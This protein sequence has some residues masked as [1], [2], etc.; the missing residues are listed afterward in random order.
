MAADYLNFS[1]PR[2]LVSLLIASEASTPDAAGGR[3]MP[4]SIC[5]YYH[6][7]AYTT[8]YTFT[9][10]FNLGCFLTSLFFSLY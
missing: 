10:K 2:K 7:C 1:L 4:R 6:S 5:K 9:L 8:Y 3:K